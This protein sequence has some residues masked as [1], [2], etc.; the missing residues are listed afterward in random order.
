M[1]SILHSTGVCVKCQ[2][3]FSGLKGK[4]HGIC[5]LERSVGGEK[6]NTFTLPAVFNDCN[7]N[8]KSSRPYC[9]ACGSPLVSNVTVLHKHGL[10]TWAPP[11]LVLQQ[12]Q[13]RGCTDGTKVIAGSQRAGRPTLRL[14]DCHS[15]QSSCPHN[16]FLPLLRQDMTIT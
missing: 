5:H 3:D 7:F 2:S 4:T 10:T 1:Y 6:Q 15:Q 9:L 13:K 8:N 12:Q 11:L 14:L 16:V